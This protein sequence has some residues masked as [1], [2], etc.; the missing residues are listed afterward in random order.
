MLIEIFIVIQ[1]LIFG[2]GALA[3]WRQHPILWAVV[4]ILAAMLA[5]SA[6]SIEY[7]SIVVSNMTSDTSGNVTQVFYTYGDKVTTSPDY[8]LGALNI[9]LFGL[10][11]VYFFVSLYAEI[12]RQRDGA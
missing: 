2:I 9:G 4:L 12:Q 11:L 10:S 8:P 1:I 6:F 3:Y 5:V 7:R